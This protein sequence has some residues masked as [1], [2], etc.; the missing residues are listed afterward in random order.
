MEVGDLLALGFNRNEAKVYASLSTFSEADA[1]CIVKD[2]GFHK[3]IVYDN[4]EKLERKGLVTH[5]IGDGRKVFRLAPAHMLV[6]MMEDKERELAEKK[7]LSLKITDELRKSIASQRHSQEAT[8]YRGV[9]G[10]RT[11][12]EETL[13]GGAYVVFGAPNQSLNVMGETFWR[14]YDAKRIEKGIRA[15]MIFTPSLRH[16]GERIRDAYTQIRYFDGRFESLTETQIQ[17]DRVGIIVWSET[18]V[19]FLIIDRLVAESYMKYFTHMWKSA[20]R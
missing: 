5:I 6:R 20:K 13:Q 9:N 3:N 18:P 11:F 15:K 10:V 7:R 2:T 17:G 16:F 1:S 8:V 14:N 19:A 4:L 12:Y